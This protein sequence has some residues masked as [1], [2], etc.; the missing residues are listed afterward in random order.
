VE[1]EVE[2][3]Y[4]G[5]W[6]ARVAAQA[7][8]GKPVPAG[9]ERYAIEKARTDVKSSLLLFRQQGVAF[10]GEPVLSPQVTVSGSGEEATGSVADCVDSSHWTPVFVATG[11]SA[12]APGQ[13]MRVMVDSTARRYEGRWAIDTS[14]AHRDRPC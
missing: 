10:R 13:P 2:A 6:A 5:Y 12:L 4:R 7:A 8:P 14:V 1:V 9:L 11:K 3:A